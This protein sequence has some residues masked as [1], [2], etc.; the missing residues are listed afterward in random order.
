MSLG[1]WTRGR[2]AAG[3]GLALLL[4]C[5]GC[6]EMGT[7]TEL[8]G[9]ADS[10]R[11][12]LPQVSDDVYGSC[13]RRAVLVAEIPAA[14]LPA[15][16]SPQAATPDCAPAEALAAQLGADQLVLV[17][18]LRALSKLGSGAAFTYGKAIGADVATVNGFSAGAGV[19]AAVVG[20]AEKA[21]AAA[22]TLGG[23]LADLATRRVR[24]REIRRI[25][26]GADP[27]VQALTAALYQAGDVD[28][29]LVLADERGVVDA[30]Y[31]GPIAA[32]QASERLALIPVQRQY[33]TDAERL[34]RR[35]E[36][37]AAY[38]LVMRQ[39]G[40][41]HAKL[42]EAARDSAGFGARVEALTPEMN[43]LRDAAAKLQVEVR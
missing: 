7:V 27:A 40:M 6:G 26:Q 37:A 34:G 15:A 17:D 3:V 32:A 13:K 18:Y 31:E 38:G 12:A 35:R 1:G 33:D 8:G 23:K 9:V 21:S 30:Y 28:Y 42:T 29:E 5:T 4:L 36:A 41:L 25:V 43:H 24:A 39:I 11:L 19:N 22:L 16:A 20:D 14:E 10:L 2:V